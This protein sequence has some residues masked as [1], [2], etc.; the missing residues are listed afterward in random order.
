MKYRRYYQAGGCYFFTVVTQHRKPVL[1]SHIAA[2][3]Q[4]FTHVK[5]THPFLIDAAVV[6]P[7]HLHMIWQMPPESSDFSLRWRI[8]K[9]ATA[10]IIGEKIW[11]PRF[12][13]HCIRNESDWQLHADYIHFN[14]VK[15]G[16]VSDPRDWPHSSYRKFFGEER[17]EIPDTNIT[18]AE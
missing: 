2:L 11:Q 14:P 9:A 12:Y 17:I 5:T 1:V 16:Y 8:F 7:D 4:A 15:H 6:L 13:E 10:R 3:K 18:G